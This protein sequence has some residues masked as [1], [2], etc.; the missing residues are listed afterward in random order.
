MHSC[1]DFGKEIQETM[2]TGR[3]TVLTHRQLWNVFWSWSCGSSV[4]IRSID[5]S[6][7]GRVLVNTG[8]FTFYRSNQFTHY[9]CLIE[10]T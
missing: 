2:K 5:P 6:D 1:M 9:L 7:A 4:T 10:I 3:K 8:R